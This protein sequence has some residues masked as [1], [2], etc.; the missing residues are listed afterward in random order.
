MYRKGYIPSYGDAQ[1]FSCIVVV[2]L[3]LLVSSGC[4]KFDVS[5]GFVIRKKKK[6]FW[7]GGGGGGGVVVVDVKFLPHFEIGFAYL[8][9]TY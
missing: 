3:L 7:C 8:S 2:H 9:S 5:E 4:G 1:W 6:S